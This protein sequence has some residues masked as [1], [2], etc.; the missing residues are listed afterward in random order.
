VGSPDLKRDPKEQKTL[1]RARGESSEQGAVLKK[2]ESTSEG[3]QFWDKKKKGEKTF[4][5]HNGA[6]IV[7]VW[8]KKLKNVRGKGNAVELF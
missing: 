4:S 3:N 7:G 8:S 1:Q 6:F 5:N 2:R